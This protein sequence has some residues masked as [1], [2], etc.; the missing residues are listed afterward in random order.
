MRKVHQQ[1]TV[2]GKA[3]EEVF[4]MNLLRVDNLTRRFRIQVSELGN[5]AET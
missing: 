3:K 4:A 1:Y 5:G 2:Q